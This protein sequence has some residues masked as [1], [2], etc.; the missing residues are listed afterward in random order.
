MEIWKRRKYETNI[1]ERMQSNT[2]ELRLLCDLVGVRS[3][4]R[5]VLLAGLL[6]E[7]LGVRKL[8][9][10]REC[11]LEECSICIHTQLAQG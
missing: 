5:P 11:K 6:T 1:T 10:M 3:E 4:V 7:G 9:S 8:A 2:E